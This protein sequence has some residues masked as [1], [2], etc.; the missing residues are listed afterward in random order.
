VVAVSLV[1][2]YYTKREYKKNFFVWSSTYLG[3]NAVL[4]KTHTHK[5][6]KKK[7]RKKKEEE[8]KKNPKF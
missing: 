2:F 8:E 4:P 7:K 6:K 5:K 1:T 3:S